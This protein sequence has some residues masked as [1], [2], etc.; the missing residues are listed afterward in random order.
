MYLKKYLNLN[1]SFNFLMI[2]GV[3]CASIC[4]GLGEVTFMSLAA[5][6]DR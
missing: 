6:F 4:G 2:L 5:F 3:V 1:V